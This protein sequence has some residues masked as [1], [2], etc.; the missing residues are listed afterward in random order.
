VGTPLGRG[1][2]SSTRE[3]FMTNSFIALEDHAELHFFAIGFIRDDSRH[4]LVLASTS[5]ANHD[6]VGASLLMTLGTSVTGVE[7]QG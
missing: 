7:T 2:F 1:R 3:R 5:L 4:D 6:A